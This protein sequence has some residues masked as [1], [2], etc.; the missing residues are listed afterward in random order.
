MAAVV[1][2]LEWDWQRGIEAIQLALEL[3]PGYVWGRQMYGQLI[4]NQGRIEEALAEMQYVTELNP[5]AASPGKIDAGVLL[6]R[7]GRVDEAVRA[8][9]RVLELEA[10]HLTSLIN[11]G[12]FQCRQ[13][14]T[15]AGL[16]LLHR[17]RAVHRETP[18]VVAEIAACYAGADRES[19]ARQYLDEL[20]AWSERDYVDPVNLAEVHLSLGDEE[21][22]YAW[23][24][25]AVAQHA[26]LLAYLPHDPGFQ[27][28][29][30]DPR[31]R[32]LMQRVGLER[33]LDGGTG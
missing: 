20:M 31:F 14:Q 6:L 11:Y 33:A 17:A 18:M 12:S 13:G 26:F 10:T 7:L 19:E 24:E 28:L 29:H 2:L 21:A 4:A 9:Q 8:W 32:Q 16:E 22:A 30:G 15:E 27:R 23:L 1:A 5:L 25:Q 3:D